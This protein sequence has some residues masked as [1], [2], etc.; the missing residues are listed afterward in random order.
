MSGHRAIAHPVT[1]GARLGRNRAGS[2]LRTDHGLT[3]L[4]AGTS[5]ICHNNYSEVPLP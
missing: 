4:L 1:V 2:S 3:T 5:G